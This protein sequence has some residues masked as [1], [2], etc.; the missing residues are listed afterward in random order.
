MD[1]PLFCYINNITQLVVHQHGNHLILDVLR[2]VPLS[3][4]IDISDSLALGSLHSKLN[5]LI[6][7]LIR[8]LSHRTIEPVVA[9]RVLL[10]RTSSAICST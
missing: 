1:Y 6:A 9:D 4:S 2:I 5:G 3:T 10:R 8:I 7:N